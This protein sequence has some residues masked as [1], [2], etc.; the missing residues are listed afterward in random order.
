MY[1]FVYGGLT[2]DVGQQ[3]MPT[4]KSLTFR[5]TERPKGCI[6]VCHIFQE[7]RQQQDH[8]DWRSYFTWEVAAVLLMHRCWIEDD[9][10]AV[11]NAQQP[12]V[13]PILVVPGHHGDG[14]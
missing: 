12:H 6:P 11:E 1:F 7:P 2:L 10:N 9:E 4:K 14:V 13:Y 5:L 8:C 3:I